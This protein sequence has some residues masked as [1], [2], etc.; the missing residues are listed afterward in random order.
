[1]QIH[2][3]YNVITPYYT[4]GICYTIKKNIKIKGKQHYHTLD[5]CHATVA[6]F[7]IKISSKTTT[8]KKTG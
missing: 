7:S 4:Y 8:K 2:K 5:I 1:M 6:L 3:I